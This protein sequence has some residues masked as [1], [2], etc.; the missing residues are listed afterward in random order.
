M[1]EKHGCVRRS[2]VR[3]GFDPQD[4]RSIGEELSKEEE[5][6]LFASS[7]EKK[8]ALAALK[9][10]SR[11]IVD[12]IDQYEADL[13]SGENVELGSQYNEQPRPR[14]ARLC[15]QIEGIH[16]DMVVPEVYDGDMPEFN[17]LGQRKRKPSIRERLVDILRW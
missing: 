1:S 6:L 13:V 12:V 7:Q 4:F 11:A 16:N 3:D 10:W 9:G 2:A 14:L 17:L 15:H 8:I 5:A